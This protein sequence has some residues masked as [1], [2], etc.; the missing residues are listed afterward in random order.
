MSMKP[1]HSTEDT[2]HYTAAI[3]V[4]WEPGSTSSYPARQGCT[5]LLWDTQ[6]LLTASTGRAH[7]GRELKDRRENTGKC[8]LLLGGGKMWI[9]PRS[10]KNS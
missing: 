4:A 9:C 7:N 3:I 8:L 2:W 1:N 5:W 10:H 6:Q